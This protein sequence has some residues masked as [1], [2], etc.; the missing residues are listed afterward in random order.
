MFTLMS[1]TEADS[2]LEDTSKK[3]NEVLDSIYLRS[4]R[5][6]DASDG[7]WSDGSASAS[8]GGALSRNGE[9]VDHPASVNHVDQQTS[10]S[11]ENVLFT[12][13]VCDNMAALQR[14][15]KTQERIIG[16]LQRDNEALLLGKKELTTQLKKVQ[17]D[18]ANLEAKHSLLL[19][20]QPEFGAPSLAHQLRTEGSGGYFRELE[21]THTALENERA[22]CLNL[23]EKLK[24]VISQSEKAKNSNTE[25]Q[26][27][28][29][30]AMCDSKDNV[31]P[32]QRSCTRCATMSEGDMI[33][34][35]ELQQALQTESEASTELHE[36]IN[37]LNEEKA[38]LQVNAKKAEEQVSH[39]KLQLG[40]LEERL[41]ARE[42]TMS[43]LVQFCHSNTGSSQ[44][45]K[46]QES[47]I[48]Q[49]EDAL[50]EKDKFTTAAME[51]L[52]R[53]M[54]EV[55]AQYES[56][57][58]GMQESM[59]FTSSESEWRRRVACLEKENLDL[60]RMIGGHK[61]PVQSKSKTNESTLSHTTSDDSSSAHEA[62]HKSIYGEAR[63]PGAFGVNGEVELQLS[64]LTNELEK[65]KNRC[66]ETQVMLGNAK[67]EWEKQLLRTQKSFASQIQTIRYEHNEEV[68][69]LQGQHQEEI[70][71]LSQRR[72]DA[73]LEKLS[74]HLLKVAEQEGSR[75]FLLSVI[76]RLC[77]LEKRFIEKEQE[78]MYEI[79]EARRIAELEDNVRQQKTNLIIE[80]KNNQ[81]RSFRA[82]VDQLMSDL[83]LI[84][85]ES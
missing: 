46:R 55:C 79:A 12:T 1:N 49:L 38:V 44:R 4:S 82:Q 28:E 58:S 18:F 66:E 29:N 78:M 34:V 48:G 6:V 54:A 61:P 69:R 35:R 36:I 41:R 67:T 15:L 53:E 5:V 9:T 52:R 13:G 83:S 43:D 20:A 47:R 23:E 11:E 7:T 71:R 31:S 21:S 75:A 80:Q 84:Q 30:R 68:N 50:L 14:E 63:S 8:A 65:Y 70:N 51:K 10:R 73:V 42:K 16:A 22:K 76:E 24:K 62:R 39:F 3:A 25:T 2:L 45:I 26:L 19:S 77:F 56:T 64:Q 81:I 74:T 60:R 57:I 59:K 72:R 40:E 33:A 27:M 37:H 32:V 85:S 17:N